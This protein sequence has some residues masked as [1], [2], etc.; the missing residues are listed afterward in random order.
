MWFAHRETDVKQRNLVSNM[1]S[2]VK[3]DYLCHKIINCRSS[4]EL[5]RLNS[6]MMVKFGDTMIPSNIS[7]EPLP[8]TFNDFVVHKID[9][10]RSNFGP[11][12][13]VPTNPVEF[14]SSVFAEF[15]L[16][17]EDF[18]KI[19]DQEMPLKSCDLNPLPTSV[20]YDCL[21]EIIPIVTSIINKSL[22]SGFVPQCFEHALVK[23]LLKRSVLISTT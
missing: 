21:D 5:S 9:E 16:V 2:K 15:E 23:P 10:I 18:A 6:Q 4:R 14:S 17:N 8:D 19:V 3:K 11:D 20:L 12:R 1:I 22:S 7:P 13:P